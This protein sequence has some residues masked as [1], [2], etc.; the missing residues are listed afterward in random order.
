MDK[1][2]RTDSLIISLPNHNKINLNVFNETIPETTR[3]SVERFIDPNRSDVRRRILANVERLKDTFKTGTI[4][5]SNSDVI[6]AIYA[7]LDPF[8]ATTTSGVIAALDNKNK[9]YSEEYMTRVLGKFREGLKN[10][11]Y[12]KN[13]SVFFSPEVCGTIFD[14]HIDY[15]GHQFANHVDS[16]QF[17]IDNNW[18]SLNNN[19]DF[20][21]TIFINPVAIRKIILD[22]IMRSTPDGNTERYFSYEVVRMS[23]SRQIYGSLLSAIVIAAIADNYRISRETCIFTL[24]ELLFDMEDRGLS[25]DLLDGEW[26]T[27]EIAAKTMIHERG[28]SLNMRNFNCQPDSPTCPMFREV[29]DPTFYGCV[30]S[31]SIGGTFSMNPKTC[32]KIMSSMSDTELATYSKMIPL[33]PK[34]SKYI[35]T[36]FHG[37]TGILVKADSS[38]EP[39]RTYEAKTTLGLRRMIPYILYSTYIAGN[40]SKMF[41]ME[42]IFVELAENLDFTMWVSAGRS[43]MKSVSDIAESTQKMVSTILPRVKNPLVTSHGALMALSQIVRD[44]GS[45]RQEDDQ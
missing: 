6:G 26:K 34:S 31:G 24:F 1:I 39:K 23:A 11:M 35:D 42:K 25:N 20:A 45:S 7:L 36:V 44:C 13:I 18:I 33:D 32:A 43:D 10:A 37:R 8:A 12:N 27:I 41:H 28:N 38:V 17:K 29:F 40:R 21:I 9:E 4:S 19:A 2:E 30:E 14:V 15:V 16:L 5:S 3:D 22:E